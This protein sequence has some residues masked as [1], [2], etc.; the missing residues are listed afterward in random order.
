MWTD[1][2]HPAILPALVARMEIEPLPVD[3][4]DG[5]QLSELQDSVDVITLIGR[6][7]LKALPAVPG[8]VRKLEAKRDDEQPDETIAA[9]RA[10]GRI[11]PAANA[12]V[13]PLARTL[14]VDTD[15]SVQIAAARALS[16]MGQDASSA[17]PD[18]IEMLTEKV[19][20]PY[21]AAEVLG[22]IGPKAAA[23][24]PALVDCLKGN[25]RNLAL[26]AG[27]SILRVDPLK[28][29]LVEAILAP[30]CKPH[31]F[32]NRACLL[33]ALGRRTPEADGFTRMHLRDLERNLSSLAALTTDDELWIHEDIIRKVEHSL[34]T[35]GR[36]RAGAGGAIERLTDLTNHSDAEVQRLARLML[37]KITSR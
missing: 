28:R 19:P 37:E 33:G 15:R 32:Y 35:L 8:L 6:L 5:V 20:G 4:K 24:V 18:L 36:L 29:G 11:G 10:L 25:D 13:V 34:D 9:A 2:D 14:K 27:L 12:A 26:A 30:I 7:G 21:F 17:V 1:A 16:A 3:P 22:S 31:H 23:A